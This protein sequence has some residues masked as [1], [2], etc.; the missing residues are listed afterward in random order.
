MESDKSCSG[1]F[2]FIRVIDYQSPNEG[3]YAFNIPLLLI[4]DNNTKVLKDFEIEAN[5]IHKVYRGL[6]YEFCSTY[7]R[8]EIMG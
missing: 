1:V 6:E 5:S 7:S 2:L 3:P 4:D 8:M